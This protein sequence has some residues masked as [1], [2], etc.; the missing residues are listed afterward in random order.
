MAGQ[1]EW[2][3]LTLRCLIFHYREVNDYKN[4]VMVIHFCFYRKSN[5]L[6]FSKSFF[7]AHLSA[8]DNCPAPPGTL[9]NNHPSKPAFG[10]GMYLSAEQTWGLQPGNL[11]WSSHLSPSL[12]IPHTWFG[13]KV[14]VAPTF[15]TVC[16]EETGEAVA[17]PWHTLAISMAVPGTVLY[18]IW[19]RR[20]RAIKNSFLY[21]QGKA[22]NGWTGLVS[23]EL[24]SHFEMGREQMWMVWVG[25]Q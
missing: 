14:S 13:N 23:Q 25:V 4:G 3:L 22:E 15:S 18:W 1:K 16:S 10:H 8:K 7:Q 11:L 21:L 17:Q 12:S 19:K 6:I 24:W 9:T 2:N 20:N 5:Q